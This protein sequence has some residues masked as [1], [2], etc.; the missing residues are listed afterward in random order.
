MK[1]VPHVIG[2]DLGKTIFHLVGLNSRGEIVV[3]KKFSPLQLLR[4][5]GEPAGVFDWDGSMRRFPLS[6]SGTARAGTRGAF[7]PGTVC[8]AV[9]ENQ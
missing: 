6:W 1:E 5:H 2:I 7:D 3:R 4:F 8:E 9:C